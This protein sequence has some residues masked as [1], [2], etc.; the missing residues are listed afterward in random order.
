MVVSTRTGLT[1]TSCEERALHAVE[2]MA[3]VCAGPSSGPS[4]LFK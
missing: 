4:G 3:V 2:T 1:I